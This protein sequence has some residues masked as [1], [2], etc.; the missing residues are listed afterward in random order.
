MQ[1]YS[2]SHLE[3]FVKSF[4]ARLHIH[5]PTDLNMLQI[6]N[7]LNIQVF[8]WPNGSQALFFDQIG[9]IFLNN[10]LSPQQQWQD[11]THELCHVLLHCGDQMHLHPLFL[12]YQEHKA[13]N[14]AFHAAIPTF[15]LD[16]LYEIHKYRLSV[17]MIQEVFNVE[18]N[19][20]KK[21]LFQY[22]EKLKCIS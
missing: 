6:A 7:E 19:F 4:Y 5:Q 11:F 2:Y 10:E 18:E 15:M 1:T 17:W 12:E 16:E 13:Q 20:A 22:S 14:F 8:Y 21:R 3:D 9:Y